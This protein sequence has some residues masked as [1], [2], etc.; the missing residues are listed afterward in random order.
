MTLG[1][2]VAEYRQKNNV[3][4]H[5]FAKKAGLSKSYVFS[6]EAGRNPATGKEIKPALETTL[7]CCKAME[8]DI[9]TFL[10]KWDPLLA[11][12]LQPKVTVK[13]S[14]APS[15]PTDTDAHS[16]TLYLPAEVPPGVEVTV[17]A[18][19][20]AFKEKRL[21]ILP[22]RIPCKGDLVYTPVRQYMMP[23][24]LTV[25][26]SGGGMFSAHAETCGT[27]IY[28]IF[29]LGRTVFLSRKEAQHIIDDW[30][31]E[32]NPILRKHPARND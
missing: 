1:D 4:L 31:A 19:L 7:M 12:E 13:P 18:V 21:L 22:S 2:I 3:S 17:D 15:K 14:P 26:E 11:R 30:L 5:G 6:L 8:M 24:A 29:D 10:R 27:K 16:P 28:S 9:V 23:V 32:E 20:S 25:T